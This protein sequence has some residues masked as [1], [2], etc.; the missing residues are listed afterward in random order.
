M[1]QEET[2]SRDID[3]PMN[4][5][6]DSE[7]KSNKNDDVDEGSLPDTIVSSIELVKLKN[8]TNV[9]CRN[10]EDEREECKEETDRRIKHV[11]DFW[12]GDPD[13]SDFLQPKSF[14]YGSTIE[15]DD[16]VREN[17]CEDYED[18]R[19]GAL[20]HW[21][22]SIN[23][24]IA[25]ILLLDQVPRN[26]Y[27]DQPKS[28][29][30]DEKALEIA[31]DVVNRGWDRNQPNIIRRYIYSPFNH[32]ENLADQERSVELYTDI[33]EK[34][35]LYWAKNFHAIIKAYGRFPHR[36]RILGRRRSPYRNK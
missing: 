30:T 11:L 7:I 15:Q 8:V 27:R 6:D 9:H 28:F 10:D 17:L 34:E 1:S 32:S 20:D 18:A 19:K 31:R 21:S 22:K 35:H 5:I 25:L 16:Y 33:G 24:A 3:S 36:D 14:W 13:D 23:G 26:I 2:V 12:F 29:E 4:D